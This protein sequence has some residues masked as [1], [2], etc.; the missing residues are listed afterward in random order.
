MSFMTIL[1]KMRPFFPIG[2][3]GILMN[4][5]QIATSKERFRL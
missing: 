1:K 3:N 5:S 4:R 2:E